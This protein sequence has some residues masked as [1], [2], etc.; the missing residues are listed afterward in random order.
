MLRPY[1][2]NIGHV[3]V[4]VAFVAAVVSTYAYWQASRS[5]DTSPESW[6]K[7]ARRAFYVHTV[8]VITICASLLSI[9]FNHYFEY[10]YA[11]DN[12][13]W[14]LPMGYAI[15]CFW[16]DQEGSFLL[17]MFWNVVLGDRKSVV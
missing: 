5:Q 3:S 17:W 16:Q 9:I 6:L 8:A 10:H 14:S 15:S 4:I 11:W 1:L 2:G 7:F 13:S 12:S